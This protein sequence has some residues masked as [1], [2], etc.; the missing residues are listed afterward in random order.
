M[1]SEKSFFKALI[2]F[3]ICFTVLINIASAKTVDYA[4]NSQENSTTSAKLLLGLGILEDSLDLSEPVTRAELAEL[5][6]KTVNSR[7]QNDNSY[8]I[9]DINDHI[10]KH[11]VITAI[12]LGFF[13]NPKSGYF[14]PDEYAYLSEAVNIFIN[15]LGYQHMVDLHGGYPIG[16]WIAARNIGLLRGI[17]GKDG[18]ILTKADAA[19]LIYNALHTDFM[20]QT[21]FGD[22]QKYQVKKEHNILSIYWGLYK[23]AGR[24][25]S[26]SVSSLLEY[27]NLA[28]NCVKIDNQIFKEGITNAGI[29]LGYSVDFYYDDT[30]QLHYI[31]PTGKNHSIQIRSKDICADSN[32]SNIRY[33]DKD[34]IITVSLSSYVDVLYNSVAHFN[35][36]KEDLFLD[37]AVIELLD[38]NDDYI[39]DTIFINKF[40]TIIV[41]NI[42]SVNL[43]ISDRISGQVLDLS[44]NQIEHT[45]FT[46][47]TAFGE[48]VAATFSSIMKNSVLSIKKSFDGKVIH[49]TISKETIHGIINEIDIDEG[50]VVI[51]DIEFNLNYDYWKALAAKSHRIDNI[52]PSVFGDFYLDA[53]GDISYAV[54]K[55]LEYNY[56]F[57]SRCHVKK[58]LD[59]VPELRIITADS[60]WDTYKLANI[61]RFNG[62]TT[63]ELKTIVEAFFIN[64][65]MQ[66]QIIRFKLNGKKEIIS[67]DKF[68]DMSTKPD[69]IGYTLGSFTKDAVLN[70][71]LYRIKFMSFAKKY[72]LRV[73]KNRTAIF[74]VPSTAINNGIVDE[75]QIHAYNTDMF[76]SDRIYNIEVYDSDEFNTASAI[77]WTDNISRNYENR[78]FYVNKKSVIF[79]EDGLP[80]AKLY[81][82]Y[83]G[84]LRSFECQTLDVAKDVVPGDIIQ[85]NLISNGKIRALNIVLTMSYN[86]AKAS[87]AVTPDNNLELSLDGRTP[88]SRSTYGIYIATVYN[89]DYSTGNFMTYTYSPFTLIPFASSGVSVIRYNSDKKIYE[90]ASVNELIGEKSG[91]VNATRLFIHDR[92]ADTQDIVILN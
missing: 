15:F 78:L 43:T 52:E 50:T 2:C 80:T 18:H 76:F 6:C 34:K 17:N 69:Y 58:S 5:L 39:Y 82:Y 9:S 54:V 83:E 53:L 63:R 79:D 44:N 64:N 12:S 65:V 77:V 37:S 60:R 10:R 35:A 49:V 61:V 86:D 21:S 89:I 57:L 71:A 26:N 85:I 47:K 22:R 25:T 62:E 8:D 90:P 32:L 48:M 23:G 27:S 72:S 73:G 36:R 75:S 88:I 20:M 11:Y 24:V 55:E 84:R 38:Y 92:Y 42:D 91:N 41:E 46:E 56:G 74:N 30:K 13:E 7:I 16:N 68:E 31:S 19:A 1:I 59:A 81:G 29:F 4:E 70:D 28:N 66:P 45:Y 67:L 14:R 3:A 40:D 87:S 51:D 33:Y